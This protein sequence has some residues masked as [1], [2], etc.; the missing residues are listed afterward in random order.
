MCPSCGRQ[1]SLEFTENGNWI[2]LGTEDI[3]IYRN[4]LDKTRLLKARKEITFRGISGKGCSL[5]Y[6]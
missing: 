3:Y 6:F 1:S 2:T 4:T 5:F